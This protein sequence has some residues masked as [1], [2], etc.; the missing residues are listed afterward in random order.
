MAAS[1]QG[2]TAIARR[3]IISTTSR[4]YPSDPAAPGPLADM[5]R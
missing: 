3:A 5:A 2:E 1:H 4:A